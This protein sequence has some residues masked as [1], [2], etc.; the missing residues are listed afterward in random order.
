M[1]KGLLSLL[2]TSSS[3]TV[4]L[5]LAHVAQAA[6]LLEEVTGSTPQIVNLN[7]VHSTFNLSNQSQNPILHSLGCTCAVCTGAS[8]IQTPF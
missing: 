2:L 3:L 4:V 5:L 7:W 1:L 8:S 6:P